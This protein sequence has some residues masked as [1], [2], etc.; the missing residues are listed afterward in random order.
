MNEKQ[1]GTTWRQLRGLGFNAVARHIEKGTLRGQHVVEIEPRPP[2][3]TSELAVLLEV[4]GTRGIEISYGK[5]SRR[6]LVLS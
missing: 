6:V 4:A 1:A 3:E 2:L 5:T